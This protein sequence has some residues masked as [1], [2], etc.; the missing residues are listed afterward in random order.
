AEGFRGLAASGGHPPPLAIRPDGTVDQ[1][2]ADGPILGVFKDAVY[3]EVPVELA[4]S[5]VL[6]LYTD[7]VTER[8]HQPEL[9]DEAQLGR[10]VRNQ[11]TLRDADDVAQVVLD[12]VM[13]VSSSE[14]RDDI[15][16]VVVRVTG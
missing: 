5:D 11:I 9:F 15:A 6:V 16:L 12:T 13:D 8:R 2:V 1:I 4:R 7:G 3:E 14:A 10:L